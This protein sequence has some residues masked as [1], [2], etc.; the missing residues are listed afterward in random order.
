MGQS[1]VPSFS[2]KTCARVS[3]DQSK[4]IRPLMRLLKRT[5]NAVRAS[6]ESAQHNYFLTKLDL[7]PGFPVPGSMECPLNTSSITRR[8]AH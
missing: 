6:A 8:S 3:P 4:Q 5:L 1:G 2:E 7:T